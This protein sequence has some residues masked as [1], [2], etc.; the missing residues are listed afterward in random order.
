MQHT[1]VKPG[2]SQ[3]S[4]TS[5]LEQL[6]ANNFNAQIKLTQSH[7]SLKRDNA[8]QRSLHSTSKSQID[9]SLIK[10][11]SDSKGPTLQTEARNSD[12]NSRKIVPTLN[13]N[14]LKLIS[15]AKIKVKPNRYSIGGDGSSLLTV[16]PSPSKE[17]HE[18]IESPE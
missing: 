3:S 12:S 7:M 9:L 15:A 6:I 8:Q 11:T 10:Q 5:H 18:T 16:G 13:M 2:L 1:K 17:V 4:S 14:R